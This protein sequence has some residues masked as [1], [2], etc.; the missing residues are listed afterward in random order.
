MTSVKKFAIQ[1]GLYFANNV[2]QP[3]G[4]AR[5]GNGWVSIKGVP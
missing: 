2:R 4:G 5:D 3:K 1:I